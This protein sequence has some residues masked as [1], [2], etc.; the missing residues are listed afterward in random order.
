MAFSLS[1]R[2]R[3]RYWKQEKKDPTKAACRLTY[4]FLAIWP[5]VQVVPAASG[6]LTAKPWSH[7]PK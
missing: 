4:R 5:S 2:N 6:C 3:L 7:R 1:R